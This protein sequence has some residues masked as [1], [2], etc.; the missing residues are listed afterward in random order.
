MFKPQGETSTI[1]DGD[2]LYRY[3]TTDAFVI[4]EPLKDTDYL[5]IAEEIHTICTAEICED[6]FQARWDLERGMSPEL[7][8]VH[9]IPIKSESVARRL[10]P[11]LEGYGFLVGTE[12][13]QAYPRFRQPQQEAGDG[14]PARMGEADARAITEARASDQ[15]QDTV[16]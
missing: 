3:A 10:F 9:G 7:V 11:D 1:K 13:P 4:I 2:V 6:R 16:G 8:L 15:S 14:D 5:L 12:Q